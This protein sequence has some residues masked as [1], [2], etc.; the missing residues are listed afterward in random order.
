MY[1]VSYVM[2]HITGNLNMFV[3]SN[4]MA[5]TGLPLGP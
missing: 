3:N 2:L 1:H 5:C 4:F